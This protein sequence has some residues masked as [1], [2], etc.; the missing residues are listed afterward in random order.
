MGDLRN[1]TSKIFAHPYLITHEIDF[2]VGFKVSKFDVYC[3]S[4][5]T[6]KDMHMHETYT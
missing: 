3:D 1:Q 6:L 4:I 2:S 5:L